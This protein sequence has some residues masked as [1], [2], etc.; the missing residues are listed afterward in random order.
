MDRKS[1]MAE[2]KAGLKRLPKAERE[3]A[4]LY[5]AEYFDDA[6]PE[7]EAEVIE[8]LGPA[9]EAAS[10]ILKDMAVKRLE[11]PK[12]SAKKGLSTLW[13]VILALCAAPIGLPLLITLF[14]VGLAALIVVITLFCV[15]LVVGV[16]FLAAGVTGIF[17]GI[18]FLM[19]QTAD[20][21]VILGSSLALFGVGLLLLLAGTLC[22]KAA[23]GGLA[24]KMKRIL[25]GGKKNE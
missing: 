14:A 3:E 22:F 5:Y 17:A 20:G 23:I 4:L 1:Y 25:T 18:Y 13:I 10:Q 16:S 8:E 6:G 15:L 9:K 2:L 24:R 11:E 19:S 21:I 7:H 12:T